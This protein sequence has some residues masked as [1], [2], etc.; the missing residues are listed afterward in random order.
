MDMRTYATA[1]VTA[2]ASSSPE[3]GVVGPRLLTS[4]SSRDFPR[5]VPSPDD[6]SGSI[7]LGFLSPRGLECRFRKRASSFR[8]MD[9]VVAPSRRTR[10]AFATEIAAA[11]K[12]SLGPTHAAI[13]TAAGWTGANE[14]TAKNWFSGRYSPNGE[15][16]VVLAR[17][18][19]EVL[20]AFLAMAGRPDL[21]AAA[22][23][24]HAEEAV[25]D[26][27]KAI[28]ALATES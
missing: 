25:S 13:K 22:K 7:P 5:N 19:D 9:W 26:L 2:P 11:L 18:S 21:I 10:H 14:R 1:G 20:N 15:L 27:L 6:G 3:R 17:N 28:R 16:L 24:A 23:L 4:T 8:A 12:R